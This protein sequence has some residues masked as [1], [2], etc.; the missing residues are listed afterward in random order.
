MAEITE[1]L[2]VFSG[3]FFESGAAAVQESDDGR[4]ETATSAMPTKHKT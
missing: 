3:A 4:L 2:M 1:S